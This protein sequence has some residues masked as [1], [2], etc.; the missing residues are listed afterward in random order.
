MSKPTNVFVAEWA[1]G[2]YWKLQ[3]VGPK[4]GEAGM[5]PAQ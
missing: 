4:V 5:P 1:S 2:G 3:E